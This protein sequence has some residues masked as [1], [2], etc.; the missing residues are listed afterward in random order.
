M[1]ASARGSCMGQPVNATD[2]L[3]G[4]GWFVELTQ[5]ATS[6]LALVSYRGDGTNNEARFHF[7]CSDSVFCPPDEDEITRHVRFAHSLATCASVTSV[8]AFEERPYL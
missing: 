1:R 5:T 2:F 8:S 7:I 6:R 3:A 4:S